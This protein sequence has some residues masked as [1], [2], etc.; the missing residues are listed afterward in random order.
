MFL[1]FFA[2]VNVFVVASYFFCPARSKNCIVTAVLGRK[3]SQYTSLVVVS[4]TAQSDLRRVSPDRV[5][6]ILGR[7]GQLTFLTAQMLTQW[8]KG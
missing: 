2:I 5:K 1:F 3:L 4:V 6:G 8:Q 7:K